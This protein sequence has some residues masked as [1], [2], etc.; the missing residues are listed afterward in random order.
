MAELKITGMQQVEAISE[1]H[2]RVV[3]TLSEEPDRL[4]GNLIEDWPYPRP[5]PHTLLVIGDT[6]QMDVE[7]NPADVSSSAQWVISGSH[8]QTFFSR[9]AALREQLR[10]TTE[11]LSAEIAYMITKAS[12]GA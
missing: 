2:F 7:G 8:G 3:F 12:E 6:L 9:V 5:R 10:E 1:A 11:L 4:T